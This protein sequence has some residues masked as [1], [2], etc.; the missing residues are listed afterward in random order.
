MKLRHAL[1]GL[2]I[3]TA[4]VLTTMPS[5]SFADQRDFWFLNHTGRT[6]AQAYISPHESSHWGSDVLGSATMPSGVGAYIEFN[7]DESSSCY[8]DFKLVF[9]NGSSQTYSGGRNLCNAHAVQFNSDH[10]TAF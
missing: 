10:S 7:A 4:L 9:T 8:F 1:K 5:R 2:I 6:I 3:V